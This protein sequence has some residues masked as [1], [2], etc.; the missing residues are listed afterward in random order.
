[1][2]NHK[3]DTQNGGTDPKVFADHGEEA[4]PAAPRDLD[5]E[6]ALQ[7]MLDDAAGRRAESGGAGALGVATNG[8]V[9]FA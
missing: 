8:C 9:Q 4:P 1:M 3:Y 5:K 7:A 6:R 2:K